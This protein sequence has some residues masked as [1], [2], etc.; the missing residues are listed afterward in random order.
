MSTKTIFDYVKILKSINLGNS[1]SKIPKEKGYARS[2]FIYQLLKKYDAHFTVLQVPN[3]KDM[4]TIFS[5]MEE[6]IVEPLNSSVPAKANDDAW[7]ELRRRIKIFYQVELHL[8][9][10]ARR[11]LADI[12][13]ESKTAHELLH[14]I[15]ELY[16]IAQYTE[17]IEQ[18]KE[19]IRDRFIKAID[20]R[21]VTAQVDLHDLPGATKLTVDQICE[22]TYILQKTNNPARVNRVTAP[23]RGRGGNSNFGTSNKC[24][25]CGQFNHQ[26]GAANCPAKGRDCYKCGRYNHFGDQCMSAPTRGRGNTRGRGRG[27]QGYQ[28]YRGRGGSRGGFRGGF[29]RGFRGGF[30]GGRGNRGRGGQTYQNKKITTEN[31]HSEQ[32]QLHSEQ[33]ALLFENHNLD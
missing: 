29:R 20:D 2:H 7:K 28:P 1:K 12:K 27:Y 30:R 13:Q 24:T 11:K 18:L 32:L 19:L 26:T 31:S 10:M 25:G 17:D 9:D 15:V 3:A 14:E 4:A 22:Y 23:S 6:D 21:R 33:L 5:F 16:E 8:K